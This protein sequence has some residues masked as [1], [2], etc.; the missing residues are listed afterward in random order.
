MRLVDRSGAFKDWNAF[1]QEYHLQNNLYL[2][3][4]QL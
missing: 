1:K 2:H 4:M 3:W